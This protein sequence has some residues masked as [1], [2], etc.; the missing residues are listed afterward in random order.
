MVAGDKGAPLAPGS[1]VAA[2]AADL[3][4]TLDALKG[5]DQRLGRVERSLGEHTEMLSKLRTVVDRLEGAMATKKQMKKLKKVLDQLD[6]IEIPD[7]A[8]LPEGAL[9]NRD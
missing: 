8:P 7:D 9:E 3:R 1:D 2:L 4:Q 6:V 5:I